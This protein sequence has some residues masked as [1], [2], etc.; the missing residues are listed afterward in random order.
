MTHPLDG[1]LLKIDRANR[2]LD[3]LKTLISDF[4]RLRP[5]GERREFD[6][7]GPQY[8]FYGEIYR[9]PPPDIGIVLGDFVHN[10][11]CAFDHVMWALAL[12]IVT[13]PDVPNDKIQFPIFDNPKSFYPTRPSLDIP[14]PARDYIETLQPYHGFDQAV[15]GRFYLAVM[16]EI[17]NADKH[18]AVPI[19][20]SLVSPRSIMSDH[21]FALGEGSFTFL[22]NGPFNH[23]DEFAR[24][25]AA[26]NGKI[27]FEPQFQFEVALGEPCPVYG[28]PL[29][30]LWPGSSLLQQ[31]YDCARLDLLP[32]LARFFPKTD[33]PFIS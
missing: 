22:R 1:A 15:P 29:L 32:T 6:P 26:A 8:I 5:Y 2:H 3:S 19:I 11:R 7:N 14:G 27:E 28:V 9:E 25:P 30:S 10:L 16:R 23:G 4:I 20:A 33:N 12:S 31:L 24:V 17:S 13:P 18:R 21:V